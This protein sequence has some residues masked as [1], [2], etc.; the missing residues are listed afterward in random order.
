MPKKKQKEIKVIFKE[1]NYFINIINILKDLLEDCV[2]KF[3]SDTIEISTL[4]K[5]MINIINIKLKNIFQESNIVEPIRINLKLDNLHK[6]LGCKKKNNNIEIV[7]K[8]EEYIQVQYVMPNNTEIYK[9]HLL[10]LDEDEESL[11]LDLEKNISFQSNAKYFTENCKN[12]SKFDESI[13]ITSLNDEIIFKSKKGDVIYK[14]KNNEYISN[15]KI[16]ENVSILIYLK[17]INIFCKCDKF[18]D[19]VKINIETDSSPLEIL[20]END[21]CFIQFY[22]SSQDQV[23]D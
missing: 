12:I 20:Y 11:N 8:N 18:I 13:I 3:T 19:N 16:E 7:F 5:S 21:D 2:I 9:I 15:I 1:K 6:I 23:Q 17:Y 10:Q 4:D 22:T 14:N